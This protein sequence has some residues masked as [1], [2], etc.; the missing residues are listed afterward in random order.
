MALDAAEHG[1]EFSCG[2]GIH[3]SFNVETI[4]RRNEDILANQIQKPM[5]LLP[6]VND[7]K[8]VHLG[9]SVVRIIA[10]KREVEESKVCV[11]FSS[12]MHGWVTRGNGEKDRFQ[13]RPDL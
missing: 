8:A 7:S 9:G 11:E 1:C 5:L 3:P 12:M 6:A 10:K 13:I 4:H 2:V